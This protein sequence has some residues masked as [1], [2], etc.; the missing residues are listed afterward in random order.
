MKIFLSILIASS[1]IV[2][3][4]GPSGGNTSSDSGK[5]QKASKP[6]PTP[7]PTPIDDSVPYNTNSQAVV[8]LNK[9]E[10][11]RKLVHV[12]TWSEWVPEVEESSRLGAEVS[13]GTA[14]N[15]TLGKDV[16]ESTVIGYEDSRLMKIKGTAGGSEATM[17]FVVR[18]M[19]PNQALIMIN[20]QMPAGWGGSKKKQSAQL[21]QLQ[22][23]LKGLQKLD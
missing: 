17:E 18:P 14:L 1:V 23:F 20:C 5:A 6:T 9:D 12:D 11:W 2:G 7:K 15:W 4:A 21:K 19:G 22:N 8:N 16:I 13:V 3:C 10:A